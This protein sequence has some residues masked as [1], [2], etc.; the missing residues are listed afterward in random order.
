[1]DLIVALQ[2]HVKQ[3]HSVDIYHF[4]LIHHTFYHPILDERFLAEIS[5]H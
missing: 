5:F 3:C 2:W 4:H 1:M